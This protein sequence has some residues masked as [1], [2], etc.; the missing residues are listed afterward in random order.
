MLK[1]LIFGG[2]S[3]LQVGLL[4]RSLRLLPGSSVVFQ[5][6]RDACLSSFSPVPVITFFLLHD[7]T[8]FA[9]VSVN[10]I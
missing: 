4:W 8:G 7:C 1:T 3:R 2:Y 5:L 9:Y 6:H 10:F